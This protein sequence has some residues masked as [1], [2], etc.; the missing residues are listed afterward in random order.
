M[1]YE[2]NV[3]GGDT[4]PAWRVEESEGQFGFGLRQLRVEDLPDGELLVRVRY[5]GVNYKDALAFRPDGNVVR[6]YPMVPGI[7]LAGTVEESRDERFRAG[8]EVLV[9]GYGLGVSHYGG[10]SRYARVPSSWAV[11]I[12]PGLGSREAMMLGTAGFTAALSVDALRQAGVEPDQ[13]PVLVTGASGGVGSA[14]V[15][16]LAKLGYEVTASSGKADMRDLLLRLGAARVISRMEWMPAADRPLG[17]QLWNGAVDCV[18]GG[19][20]AAVLGTLR[21]GGAVAASGMTGGIALNTS[22]FPFIL[23]GIRLIGI[24][25]VQAPMDMRV[26]IWERL[27]GPWKPDGLESLLERIPLERVPEAV[28]TLLRGESRG[29]YVIELP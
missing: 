7:D 29:R 11:R 12:P 14:A 28:D 22:V 20:L 15:A 3:V 10:Y 2:A 24:D 9:T 23:R 27:A 26:R 18:G 16:I 6:A 5:S 21:Y 25:S 19:T 1:A 4:F 8:D 13:G 17:A